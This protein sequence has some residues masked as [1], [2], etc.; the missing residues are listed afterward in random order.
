MDIRAA[1]YVRASSDRQT[2]ENQIPSHV[3][4]RSAGSGKSS[5]CN[6][7]S[8][9]QS[10]WPGLS[11]QPTEDRPRQLGPNDL[12]KSIGAPAIQTSRNAMV[13]AIF[14]AIVS[15]ADRSSPWHVPHPQR[16]RKAH[17]QRD[18]LR[19]LVRGK[20]CRTRASNHP[21]LNWSQSISR[22]DCSRSP[23]ALE[24]RRARGNWTDRWSWFCPRPNARDAVIQVA[25]SIHMTHSAA[26]AGS[27]SKAEVRDN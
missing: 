3:G 4:S 7:K 12:T 14:A 13:R 26:K 17:I 8:P 20:Q 27:L 23:Q 18:P 9:S 22:M 19:I 24:F 16:S 5:L 15:I 11:L 6:R 25:R 21:L 2:I 10:E 1:I